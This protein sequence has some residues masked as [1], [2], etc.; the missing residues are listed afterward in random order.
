MKP[1]KIKLEKIKNFDVYTATGDW[2]DFESQANCIED[3]K[4]GMT[5][6]FIINESQPQG[7]VPDGE[8][9]MPTGEFWV[10]V[11]GTLT[12]MKEAEPDDLMNAL[13]QNKGKILIIKPRNGTLKIKV[14]QNRFSNLKPK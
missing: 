6:V 8:Y 10:F 13:K 7:G 14:H 5:A 3:I 12:E 9:C 1:G 11:K 4:I 2:L